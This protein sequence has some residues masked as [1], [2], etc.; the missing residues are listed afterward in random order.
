MKTF[1]NLVESATEKLYYYLKDEWVTPTIDEM[2]QFLILEGFDDDVS[3]ETIQSY[4]E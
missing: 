2:Y 4:Y 1:E 3:I